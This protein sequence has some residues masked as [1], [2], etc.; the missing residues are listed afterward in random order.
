MPRTEMQTPTVL[1]D[2]LSL[3]V[4]P[5]S[6]S[7]D[8]AG[9]DISLFMNDE[10]FVNGGTTNETP[11]LLAKL[12]DENGIN[13]VGSGIGHDLTAVLDEN[14]ENAIVLNDFYEADLNTYKSG[15]VLILS[16]N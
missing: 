15:I 9:P 14:T 12:F 10:N 5:I 4:L 2:P 8:Q 13:T 7:T 11:S 1:M 3:E 6:A 16:P